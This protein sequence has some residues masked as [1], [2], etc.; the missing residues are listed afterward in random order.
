VNTKKLTQ[1]LNDDLINK[2]MKLNVKLQLQQNRPTV[3]TI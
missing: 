1:Q 3:T 2:R